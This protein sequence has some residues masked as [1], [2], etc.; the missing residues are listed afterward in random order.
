M[1]NEHNPI[2]YRINKVSK[3]WDNTRLKNPKAK[4]FQFLCE[5]EDFILI[6]GFIQIEASQHGKSNDSFLMFSIDFENENQFLYDFIEEWLISFGRDLE[7]H[8][9]WNW[10]DYQQ[11]KNDF[12]LLSKND[13]HNLNKF[14]IELLISFKKFEAKKDNLIIIGLVPKNISDIQTFNHCIEKIMATIPDEYGLLVV[15]FKGKEKHKILSS[16]LHP[17]FAQL[18]LPNQNMAGSYKE[19]ATQ[20]NPNDPQV[21]FR[22]CLFELGESAAKNDREQVHHWGKK[23]LEITQSTGDRSFWASAHL[24]YAGFLFQFKDDNTTIKLL[25]KG[26]QIVKPEYKSNP[27]TAGTLMQLYSYKASYY[28]IIGKTDEAIQNFVKQSK[29]AEEVDMIE[30]MILANIYALLLIKDENNNLYKQII[31]NCFQKGYMLSDELLKVINFAFITEQ[32]LNLDNINISMSERQAIEQRMDTIYGEKWREYA[33]KI[34]TSIK[35]SF[36]NT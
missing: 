3:L 28:S 5:Q 6:N 11:I 23:L 24:M 25:D 34:S 14:L 2:A 17:L 8:K 19:L 31:Q 13:F 29:I 21:K 7:N 15:D 22:K 20:G 16:K 12:E 33:K 30:Q 32:Y 1:N 35:P 10:E 27:Q 18:T 4:F 9:E 26:I 36:E